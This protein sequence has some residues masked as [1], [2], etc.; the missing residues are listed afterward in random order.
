MKLLYKLAGKINRKAK[1]VEMRDFKTNL[2]LRIYRSGNDAAN[3]LGLYQT[4]LYFRKHF[5]FPFTNNNYS[6]NKNILW[7]YQLK[8]LFL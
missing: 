2:L 6:I 3:H 8:F 4:G 7:L 1:P 5:L